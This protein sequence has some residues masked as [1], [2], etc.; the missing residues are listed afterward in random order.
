MPWPKG[1]SS[2]E[3]CWY[4]VLVGKVKETGDWCWEGPQQQEQ[5]CLRKR[6]QVPAYCYFLG[7]LHPWATDWQALPAS[8]GLS[9]SVTVPDGNLILTEVFLPRFGLAQELGCQKF[10][11]LKKDSQGLQ[12]RCNFRIVFLSYRLLADGFRE[13]KPLYSKSRGPGRGTV[14]I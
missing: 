2:A 9:L 12:R 7:P 10:A 13:R 14:G 5:I 8:V 3:R 11:N 1:W 6:E 4:F